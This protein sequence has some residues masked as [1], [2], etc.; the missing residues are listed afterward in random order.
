[1]IRAELGGS[2]AV[3]D[4]TRDEENLVKATDNEVLL[5]LV[6]RWIGQGDDTSL[7]YTDDRDILEFILMKLRQ[8]VESGAA[9]FLIQVRMY[10][11]EHLNERADNLADLGKVLEMKDSDWDDRTTRF[12][13]SFHDRREPMD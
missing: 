7:A 1:M 8:M 4:Y 2:V 9:T 10:R 6:K 3:L 13:C 11:E 12:V 5:R